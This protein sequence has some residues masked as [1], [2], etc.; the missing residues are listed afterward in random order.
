MA[1]SSI[2]CLEHIL[3]FKRIKGNYVNNYGF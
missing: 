1:K 3:N 2:F